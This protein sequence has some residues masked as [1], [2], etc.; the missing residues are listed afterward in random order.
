M[1]NNSKQEYKEFGTNQ[2]N[3]AKEKAQQITA[4]KSKPVEES[5]TDNSQKADWRKGNFLEQK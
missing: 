1:D 4:Q 3:Q 5:K 2:A